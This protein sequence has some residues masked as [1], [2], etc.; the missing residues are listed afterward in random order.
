ME[1]KARVKAAYGALPATHKENLRRRGLGQFYEANDWRQVYYWL[2]NH[3]RETGV[4][5]PEFL[6]KL[7]AAAEAIH[8]YHSAGMRSVLIGLTSWEKRVVGECLRAVAYGPFFRET[9]PDAFWAE[10][11]WDPDFEIVFHMKGQ[12]LALVADLWPD[13]DASDEIVYDAINGSFNNLFHYPH[14][15]HHLWSEY[16]ST[17]PDEARDIYDW[18]KRLSGRIR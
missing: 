3:A 5:R 18:F 6:R 13:V 14:G 1:V 11:L 15:K 17:T 4:A 2:K 8:A 9:D 12:E 7:S 10:G 16:I